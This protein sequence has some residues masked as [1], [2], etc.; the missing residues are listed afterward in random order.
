MKERACLESLFFSAPSQEKACHTEAYERWSERQET[1]SSF[2]R[3]IRKR[4][5]AGNA[6]LVLIS[7]EVVSLGLGSGFRRW[8]LFHLIWRLDR[9]RFDHVFIS[10]SFTWAT[11][12]FTSAGQLNRDGDSLVSLGRLVVNQVPRRVHLFL[13][14]FKK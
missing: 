7:K 1:G 10:S 13:M 8:R 11:M 9:D 5:L 12:R 4:G 14:P 3:P 6:R 2:V